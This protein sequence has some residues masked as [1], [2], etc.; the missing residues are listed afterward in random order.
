MNPFTLP[1]QP[2]LPLSPPVSLGGLT[3]HHPCFRLILSR[4]RKTRP[5]SAYL[6]SVIQSSSHPS[7]PPFVYTINMPAP[8]RRK[9]D[10]WT[11]TESTPVE[12]VTLD[13]QRRAAGL[14]GLKSCKFIPFPPGDEP[15]S[16][17][18]AAARLKPDQG[19]TEKGCRGNPL[20]YNH[21]GVDQVSSE[22][23]RNGI[24]KLTGPD[25]GK[26]C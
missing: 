23:Y 2:F 17:S 15:E 22:S 1:L 7:H 4:F 21:L 8:K 3:C 26:E 24:S 11:W 16:S 10:D 19:C 6:T 9:L 12:G 18:A 13:H 25:S 20:C 14:V 5:T